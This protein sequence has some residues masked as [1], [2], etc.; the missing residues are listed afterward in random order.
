MPAE[1]KLSLYSEDPSK[2]S[3][4]HTSNLKHREEIHLRRDKLRHPCH[5]L[6]MS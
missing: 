1:D 5:P 3:K 4:L 6:G 2:S